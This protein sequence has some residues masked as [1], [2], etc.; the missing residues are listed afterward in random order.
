MADRPQGRLQPQ[1]TLSKSYVKNLLII[2]RFT[3][4]HQFLVTSPVPSKP[5]SYKMFTELEKKKRAVQA[6]LETLEKIPGQAEVRGSPIVLP[7]LQG[8]LL[9]E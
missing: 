7:Q 9:P 3:Q 2:D 5:P 6:V 1:S 8:N 4:E